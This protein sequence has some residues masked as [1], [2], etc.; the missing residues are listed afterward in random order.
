MLSEPVTIAL[1]VL[2][3]FLSA[4]ASGSETAT[5]AASR[6]VVRQ[7]S[8]AGDGRARILESLLTDREQ[9][10]ATL[11]ITNNLVN[12]LG[13]AMA[14][15]LLV[16]YTG[17]AGVL[18]A[19]GLMTVTLV[20]LGEVLPKTLAMRYAERFAL[21]LAPLLRVLIVLFAPATAM[22]RALLMLVPA[23]PHGLGHGDTAS[24]TAYLRAAITL[25]VERGLLRRAERDMLEG[26]VDLLELEVRHVFTHRSRMVTL[27]AEASPRAVLP[28]LRETPFSRFPVR[29]EA[30]DEIVGIVHIRDILQCLDDDGRLRE[31]TKLRDIMRPP[32]FVPITTPLSTQLFAFRERGQHMALVVD[33]Y[34]SLQGLVTL[35]DIVEEVVGDI[36]DE[37]DGRP[38]A[39]VREADGSVLVDGSVPVRSLN[40]QMEWELPADE[41]ATLAGLVIE[42]LGRI[43]ETGETVEIDGYVIEVVRRQRHRLALLRVR[44]QKRNEPASTADPGGSS[45]SQRSQ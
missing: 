41:A 1:I 20:V 28:L 31:D 17:E 10:I 21:T 2:L 37:K 22:L 14:T 9:L 27:P 34:G 33:E 30:P 38:A 6:I 4:L 24:R 26:V 23:A 32:W 29:A 16:R 3:L 5:T 15:E 11:L 12:I 8:R 36:V 42:T 25:W 45:A 18:L 39:I 44:R 19:T 35:E 7:A 13:T 43:P 40:R